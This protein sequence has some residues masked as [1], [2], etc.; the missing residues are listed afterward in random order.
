MMLSNV[1]RSSMYQGF[2]CTKV[3]DGADFTVLTIL[4]VNPYAAGG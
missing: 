3:F 1:G 4:L 2:Q